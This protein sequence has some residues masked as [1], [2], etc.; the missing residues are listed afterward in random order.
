MISCPQC[1]HFYFIN[2]DS[3]YFTCVKCK[4]KYCADEKCLKKWSEHNGKSCKELNNS[5]N[6]NYKKL[7]EILFEEYDVEEDLNRNC[8]DK[9]IIS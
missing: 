3:Q 4:E 8:K 7:E 9:C 5:I 1:E 2:S 6:K